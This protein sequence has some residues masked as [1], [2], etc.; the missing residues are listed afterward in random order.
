MVT[1]GLLPFFEDFRVVFIDVKDKDKTVY[2]PGGKPFFKHRVQEFPNPLQVRWASFPKHFHLHVRSGLAGGGSLGKQRR[3][4]LTAMAQAYKQKDW[5]IVAD[6]IG[7]LTANP[8]DG[9]GLAGTFKD[10]WRRGRSNTTLIAMTQEPTWI[11]SAA[12][13]QPQHLYLGRLGADGN[14]RLGEIG[15]SIDYHFVRDALGSVKKRQFLYVD[16]GA[17]EPESAMVVTGL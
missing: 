10:I 8:P 4:I 2:P 5:I 7:F 17:D 12:Y 16:K 1:R 15:A 11:P 3:T 6:E 14:K 9:L 13:S